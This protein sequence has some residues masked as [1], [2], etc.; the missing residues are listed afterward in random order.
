M[1]PDSKLHEARRKLT[2]AEIDKAQGVP[3]AG[4]RLE[5]ARRHFI[6]VRNTAQRAEW[7]EW[8]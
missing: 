8:R 1:L 6:Q 7:R 2:Q 5:L 3:G 4:E